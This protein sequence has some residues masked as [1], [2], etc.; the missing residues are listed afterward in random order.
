ME[1]TR[2]TCTIDSDGLVYYSYKLDSG[3]GSGAVAFDTLFPDGRTG[4]SSAFSCS[5]SD[6][7]L[8]DLCIDVFILNKDGTVTYVV[9]QPKE[10]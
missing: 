6:T 1:S 7:G 10:S 4:I 5:Y 9:Y 8:A 2:Q 3:E